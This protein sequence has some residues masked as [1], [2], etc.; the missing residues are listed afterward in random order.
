MIIGSVTLIILAIFILIIVLLAITAPIYLHL[1]RFGK[2]PSGE[3]LE[4]IRRSPNYRD[5]QFH[6]LVPTEIMTSKSF[7]KLLK[8][9]NKMVFGKKSTLKPP[10]PLPM[11]KRDLQHLA[12]DD[13]FYVWFGHSS[14]LLSIHGVTILVDPV[15]IT[16][17]P[18][19]FVN[20]PFP[21]TDCYL[22]EDMP[23]QIDILVITHDHYDHLDC[24]TIERIKGRVKRVVCPLGV[25][26]HL[27]RWGIL[28]EQLI[29][30]DWNE[31]FS[32]SDW[33]VHCLPSQHFSG[34]SFRRNNTLWASFLLESPHGKYFLGCDG[35]YGPH[36]RDIGTKHPDIDVAILEN[37]QYNQHWA[38]IH[39]LPEQL[40]LAV[41]D[42]GAKQVITV[43]HSKYALSLH[44]WDEPLH[45]ELAARDEYGFNLLVAELGEITR[46]RH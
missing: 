37:G 40:G 1:P 6:N 5:G 35:G 13:D 34:R 26:E 2:F 23:E 16:A 45:N 8:T 22:P 39:T 46:L 42:L 17:S 28:P 11:V 38:G 24:E 14:Y 31:S 43:H 36:F 18:V 41:K 33:T 15:F 32:I 27:E 4:R 3:R 19:S 12:P 29:E 7:G 20:K 9:F 10:F 25:G 44:P 21:G 30:M